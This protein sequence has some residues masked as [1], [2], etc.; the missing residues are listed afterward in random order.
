MY[1]AD[2]EHLGHSILEELVTADQ[3]GSQTAGVINHELTLQ[4]KVS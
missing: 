2:S 4:C 1:S 3:P